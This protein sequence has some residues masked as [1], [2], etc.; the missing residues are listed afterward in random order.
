MEDTTEIEKFG[1]V[2]LDWMSQLL[3]VGKVR[4]TID[5]NGYAEIC[6][7]SCGLDVTDELFSVRVG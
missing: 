2:I 3:K 5:K 6:R 4:D 7:C 1:D